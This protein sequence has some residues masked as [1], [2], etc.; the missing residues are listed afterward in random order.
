MRKQNFYSLLPPHPRFCV[1]AWRQ[2]YL[3]A[4]SS[5]QKNVTSSL[6]FMIDSTIKTNF[7]SDTPVGT[8][9]IKFNGQGL[10]ITYT[11]TT[12]IN[13]GVK[14]VVFSDH[15]WKT[16]MNLENKILRTYINLYQTPRRHTTENGTLHLRSCGNVTF[17]TYIWLTDRPAHRLNECL[18]EWLT[19]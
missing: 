16:L 5:R 15:S 1:V 9:C 11:G 12:L 13:V 18:L 8:F 7:L 3:R 4:E 6:L 10:V 14:F 2:L 19:D 17:E